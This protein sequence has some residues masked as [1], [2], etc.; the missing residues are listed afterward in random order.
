MQLDK[1]TVEKYQI[2]WIKK[3]ILNMWQENG[4][5]SVINQTQIM[6]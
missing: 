2:Y 1:N 5:L 6:I 3:A 4:T